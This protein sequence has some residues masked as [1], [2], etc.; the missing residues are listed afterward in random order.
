MSKT[1]KAAG[2]NPNPNPPVKTPSWVASKIA[3]SRADAKNVERGKLKDQSA[4]N[5]TKTREHFAPRKG[6]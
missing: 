5:S 1:L 3:T 4:T 6:K 2:N